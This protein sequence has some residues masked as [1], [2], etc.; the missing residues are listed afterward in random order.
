[1]MDKRA[2]KLETISAMLPTAVNWG[3]A[4]SEIGIIG[5][6][7][8]RGVMRDLTSLLAKQNKSAAFHSPRTLW[9]VLP[10][11][12]EFIAGKSRVFVIEH[13]QEGQLFRLLGGALASRSHMTNITRYDGRAFSPE[14]LFRRL[15]EEGADL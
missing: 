13:N 12:L 11:T 7:M 5:V 4:S 3:D 9:P 8:E 15:H 2:R 1:M 10:E 14:D 6:G